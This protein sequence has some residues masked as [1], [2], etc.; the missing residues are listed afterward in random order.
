MARRRAR[1]SEHAVADDTHAHRD[2]GTPA[3]Q[4]T[5]GFRV[6][7]LGA[8]VAVIGLFVAG[9]VEWLPES[10][11]AGRDDRRDVLTLVREGRWDAVV[12]H[13][14]MYPVTPPLVE[15]A[16]LLPVAVASRGVA[17][18]SESGGLGELCTGCECAHMHPRLL[19]VQVQLVRSDPTPHLCVLV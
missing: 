11:G 14:E 16:G 5:S 1:H 13:T 3:A 8:G 7:L 15:L 6:A 12:E 10:A 4:P 19:S 17:S 18:L 9:S 2:S